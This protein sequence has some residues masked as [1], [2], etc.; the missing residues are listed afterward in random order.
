MKYIADITD[1]DGIIAF[2]IIGDDSEGVGLK[3]IIDAASM[4]AKEI[5]PQITTIAYPVTPIHHRAKG[6]TK[7]EGMADII[8]EVS[9]LQVKGGVEVQL[10]TIKNRTNIGITNE[11]QT[12]QTFRSTKH[13]LYK[14]REIRC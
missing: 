8:Y 7:E 1:P 3:N 5:C 2:Q 9:L 14:V 4:V 12:I 10:K 13:L 11:P 6:Q